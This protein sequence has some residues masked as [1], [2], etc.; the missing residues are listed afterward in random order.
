MK[1]WKRLMSFFCM[2]AMV[3]TYGCGAKVS[4]ER[5]YDKENFIGNWEAK[6][7]IISSPSE[8][9]KQVQFR[10]NK[11]GWINCEINPDNTFALDVNLE[12]DVVVGEDQ[13][14]I[15]GQRVLVQGGYKMFTTGN[16]QYKDSTADFYNYNRQKHFRS[17]LYTYGSYFYLTYTDEKHNEWHL[18]FARTN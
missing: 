12:R 16:Y 13:N 5:K 14:W 18:Q 15:T 11:Y 3:L 17:V 2:S 10:V 9:G 6:I 4:L 8:G 7:A 1:Q